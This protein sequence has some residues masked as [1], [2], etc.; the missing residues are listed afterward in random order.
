MVK[1]SNKS[2]DSMTIDEAPVTQEE[3]IAT[4]AQEAGID[5]GKYGLTLEEVAEDEYRERIFIKSYPEYV[6]Y[7][8]TGNVHDLNNWYGQSLAND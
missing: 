2:G 1:R 5:Y 8:I 3:M 6:K 7:V 4:L